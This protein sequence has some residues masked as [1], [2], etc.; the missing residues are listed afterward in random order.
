MQHSSTSPKQQQIPLP[1]LLSLSFFYDQLPSWPFSV[2]HRGRGEEGWGS[3]YIGAEASVYEDSRWYDE[4]RDCQT[5]PPPC[6]TS[7]CKSTVMSGVFWCVR[8]GH[9]SFYWTSAPSVH[10]F[11]DHWLIRAGWAKPVVIMYSQ[12]NLLRPIFGLSAL[13]MYIVHA[14]LAQC[15][16]AVQAAWLGCRYRGGGWVQM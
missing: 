9:I 5:P 13:Y 8:L 15:P 2:P 4:A 6:S 12:S 1:S 11:S 16:T 3:V 10:K 7:F 14:V